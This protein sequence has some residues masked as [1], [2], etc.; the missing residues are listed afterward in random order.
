M[1]GLDEAKREELSEHRGWWAQ[2]LDRPEPEAEGV[3]DA[4]GD[5]N[6]ASTSKGSR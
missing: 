1:K 5:Q 4:N 2:F 6:A 3:G